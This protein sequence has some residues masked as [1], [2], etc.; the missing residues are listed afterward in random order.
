M[1]AVLL[2][3]AMSL[4]S[5]PCLTRKVEVSSVSSDSQTVARGAGASIGL[6]L[7]ELIGGSAPETG[8]C[9]H[10]YGLYRHPRPRV[11]L[12]HQRS[13]VGPEEHQLKHSKKGRRARKG[14]GCV[15]AEVLCA[16]QKGRGR[17]RRKI[18][19]GRHVNLDIK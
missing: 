12:E 19:C 4:V 16:Q 3:E 11:L 7:R 10:D 2:T 18:V 9:G 15:V 6:V 5:E 17:G 1:C 14:Q 8:R 13:R